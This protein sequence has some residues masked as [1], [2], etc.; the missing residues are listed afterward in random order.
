M[1]RGR[2]TTTVAQHATTVVAGVL[3]AVGLVLAAVL[4]AAPAEASTYRYWTYWWG[5]GSG[6]T[7]QGWTFAQVG[8]AGHRVNDTWVLGWRYETSTT[9][10]ASER[11]RQSPDFAA[12]CPSLA[13]VAGQDRVAVVVDYGTATDAPPG[14][15]PPSTST[16]RV[17]CLTLPASPQHQTGVQALAAANV[18]VRSENGLVCAL[19]GYPVGECAPVIPDPVASSPSP[20]PSPSSSPSSSASGPPP[21]TG[22]PSTAGTAPAAAASRTP[23]SATPTPVTSGRASA[24]GGPSRT[25][26]ASSSAAVS[27]SSARPASAAGSPASA[28]S[29]ATPAS[30]TVSAATTP[31]P[32]DA[33]GSGAGGSDPSVSTDALLPAA[34]GAPATAP[35]PSGSPVGLLVGATVVALIAGSAWWTSRRRGPGA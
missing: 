33:T 15:S 6:K 24:P 20:S 34:A 30:A 8:P 3:V 9:T 26:T 5:S 21:S 12:L 27:V 25:S 28:T 31:G 10:T 11:P 4:S 22:A 18:T 23:V 16:V 2:R 35:Q 7:A 29:P 32:T 1:T 17:E 14:Q 13:A 19:D